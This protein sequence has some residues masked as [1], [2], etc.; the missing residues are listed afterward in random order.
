MVSKERQSDAICIDLWIIFIFQ[1]GLATQEPVPLR[2]KGYSV[3]FIRKS[4]YRAP[5]G[6]SR[7][8][9]GAHLRLLEPWATRLLS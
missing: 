8:V 1:S 7:V 9:R 3:A 5:L 6:A 2:I 4:L